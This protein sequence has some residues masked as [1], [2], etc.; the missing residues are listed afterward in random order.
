MSR[1]KAVKLSDEAIN[2]RLVEYESRFGMASTEFYE[3][4]TKG[5]LEHEGHT[6]DYTRW[7]T[8]IAF[9]RE[10]TRAHA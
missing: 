2:A 10:R 1:V 9:R 6:R 5:E 3:R 7:A 4:F 8:L